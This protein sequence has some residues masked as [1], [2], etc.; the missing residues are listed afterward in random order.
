MW[1]AL[2]PNSAPMQIQTFRQRLQGDL[3]FAVSYILANN[4]EAVEERLRALGHSVSNVDDIWAILNEFLAD[5]NMKDFR[6]VLA[7]PMLTD[8][9]DA[10]QSG[11]VLQVGQ[12]MAQMAA[13]DGRLPH[14]SYGPQTEN[15][16]RASGWDPTNG[17]SSSSSSGGNDDGGSNWSV[18]FAN[19]FGALV[20]GYTTIM[21]RGGQQV[22]QVD[23]RADA[24]NAAAGEAARK[25][26]KTRYTLIAVGVGVVALVAIL[27]WK[28]WK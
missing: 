10:A 27:L 16:A 26:K 24:A 20:D 12:G 23:T 18:N 15:E 17:W 3:N 1:S 25:A 22:T 8:G 4:P 7:V 6:E 5:G 2:G 21:G 11:V 13:P 14:K 28:P 19:V 9:V